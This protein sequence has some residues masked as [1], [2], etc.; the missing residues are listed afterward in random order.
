MELAPGKV[1][2]D[3]FD[4]SCSFRLWLAF[5]CERGI[6]VKYLPKSDCTAVPKKSFEKDLNTKV[7]DQV[8]T[9]PLSKPP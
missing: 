7:A 3:I 2:F 4:R 8:N 5:R 1:K 9:R 6:T